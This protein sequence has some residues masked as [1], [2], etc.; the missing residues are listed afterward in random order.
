M[1]TRE[2]FDSKLRT[3]EEAPWHIDYRTLSEKKSSLKY[4]VPTD[5]HVS[6]IR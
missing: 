4:E 2:D 5:F 3:V 1:T 6:A